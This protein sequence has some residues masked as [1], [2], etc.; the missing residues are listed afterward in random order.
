M[1]GDLFRKLTTELFGWRWVML[2]DHDGARRVRRVEFMGGRP[3]ARR[4]PYDIANA[5]LLDG[6][7]VA[8][9]SYVTGWEPYEPGA[10]PVWPSP[11]RSSAA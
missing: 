11:R 10:E 5:M 2:I 9:V 7:A 4:H 3:F 8:G 1:K 6:G